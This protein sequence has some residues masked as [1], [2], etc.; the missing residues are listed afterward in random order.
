MLVVFNITIES[1]RH[2]SFVVMWP[3]AYEYLYCKWHSS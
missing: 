2:G 1:C 3:W